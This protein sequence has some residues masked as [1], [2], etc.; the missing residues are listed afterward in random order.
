MTMI[1][2]IVMIVMI[3]V[4]V[5]MMA[6]MRVCHDGCLSPVVGMGDN[7]LA[8]PLC[9]FAQRHNVAHPQLRRLLESN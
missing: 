7:L 9:L 3:M 2:I 1:M 8:R 5:V 4:M 6:I